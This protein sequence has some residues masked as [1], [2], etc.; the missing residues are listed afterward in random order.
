MSHESTAS[1]ELIR[2]QRAGDLWRVTLDRAERANALTRAMLQQ[3]LETFR[4]AAE[5]KDVRA[6]TLTGQ[7]ERVFCA[8]ADLSELS[9]DPDNPADAIWDEMSD[10]LGTL[11]ILTIALING[12]C[13]GG[14][15]TLALNCDIRLCVPEANF[16]Y[17]VMRNGVLPSKRDCRQLRNLIGPGRT[18]MLL[19]GG[20]RVMATEAVAWGLVDRV[21]ERS[22][23]ATIATALSETARGADPA[24]IKAIKHHCLGDPP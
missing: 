3:L 24:H 23:L 15:M 10:V 11:P 19:L 17:P 1:P 22:A 12:P 9:T 5:D 21:V 6:L 13:I 4:H 16:S 7:G 8:V 14:G 18:S 2:T 20:E